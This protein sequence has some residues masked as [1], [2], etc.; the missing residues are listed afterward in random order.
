M[1]LF[2]NVGWIVLLMPPRLPKSC[3]ER[4]CSLT[5]T[6]AHGYCDKHASLASWGKYQQQRGAN[7]YN[8]RKWYALRD[9]VKRR[10][11]GLCQECKRNNIVR[12]GTECDHIV[13]LSR[14]GDMYDINNVELLCKQCHN[15]K[16]ARGE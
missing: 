6:N 11:Q 10:D 15:K 9:R 5:T 14:G 8:N 7:P 3:R 2:I 12:A 4:G 16:T 13:S 1:R